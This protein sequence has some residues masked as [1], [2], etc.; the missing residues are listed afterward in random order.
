M[1][2]VCECK[3]IQKIRNERNVITAYILRDSNGTERK[4]DSDTLKR[5]IQEGSV[6]VTNLKMDKQGRLL[7]STTPDNAQ[8]HNSNVQN[9]A[10]QHITDEELKRLIVKLA[11][12]TNNRDSEI[13][14]ILAD[15][16]RKN[17]ELT[18]RLNNIETVNNES[19]SDNDSNDTI[20]DRIN[21]AINY[22]VSNG[23]SLDEIKNDINNM[24]RSLANI[25][26][27]AASS[28][29]KSNKDKYVVI[30][31]EGNL[32]E[33]D[34]IYEK[35]IYE[36]AYTFGEN[37][38]VKAT[39]Q[40]EI[41]TILED[42]KQELANNGYYVMNFDTGIQLNEVSK[43]KDTVK[44]I[45]YIYYSTKQ[46]FL[47]QL[48][49]YGKHVASVTADARTAIGHNKIGSKILNLIDDTKAGF[50]IV[51]DAANAL[52]GSNKSKQRQL[53][54]N[55]KHSTKLDAEK[56]Y[57]LRSTE[58]GLWNCYTEEFADD[59][60]DYFDTKAYCVQSLAC[61][62]FGETGVK[63]AGV[64]RYYICD[65]AAKQI[66]NIYDKN[67][68]GYELKDAERE[69][70]IYESMII[71]YFSAKKTIQR[72]YN[73][74]VPF[75]NQ[76]YSTPRIDEY[77]MNIMRITLLMCSLKPA[78][79]ENVLN[80]FKDALKKNNMYIGR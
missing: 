24:S 18:Q 66:Y 1:S 22:L 67:V 58:S 41:T 29:N 39:T 61:S 6:H 20:E 52:I 9:T 3:C 11:R 53:K 78:V 70:K 57:R 79:V 59:T 76:Q 40:D 75:V 7:D 14:R 33:P 56:A 32:R 19:N 5:R 12:D 4:V 13:Q 36:K 65:T 31:F 51:A 69:T 37:K 8:A 55:Y 72:E 35:R 21:N 25:T 60:D 34:D 2:Q 15:L 50:R 74:A 10:N 43:L 23:H 80:N 46:L 71:A 68:L 28:N 17:A 27:N 77:A 54:D 45:S 26:T 47:E 30:P 64:T 62:Y 63:D 73:G 38:L 42:I 16:C 49:D 44:D 48:D